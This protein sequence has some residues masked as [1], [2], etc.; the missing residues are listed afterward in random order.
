MKN[1]LKPILS[2]RKP[3]KQSMPHQRVDEKHQTRS[4]HRAYNISSMMPKTL[5]DSNMNKNYNVRKSHR[6]GVALLSA[7]YGMHG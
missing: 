4:V 1:Q 2:E 5:H 6:K 7:R 3:Y